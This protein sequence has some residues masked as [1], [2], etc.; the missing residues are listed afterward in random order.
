MS[1]GFTSILRLQ[2]AWGLC[3]HDHQV[4][5]FSHLMGGGGGFTSVNQ[6]GTFASDTV[7]LAKKFLWAFRNILQKNPNKL[8]GQP[9]I[10]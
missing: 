5:S 3:A 7:G 4:V 9:N 8:F 2:E 6:L 10:I 1:Q